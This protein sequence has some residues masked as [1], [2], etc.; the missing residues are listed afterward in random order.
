MDI[1]PGEWDKG[2]FIRR[3]NALAQELGGG[4]TKAYRE[5]DG[6]SALL[7]EA[8]IHGF[9]VVQVK[10]PETDKPTGSYTVRPLSEVAT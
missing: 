7:R 6:I 3:Y 8:R 9:A 10:D 1:E 4:D 5:S 2:D